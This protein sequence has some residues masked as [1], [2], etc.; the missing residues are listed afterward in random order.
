LRGKIPADCFVGAKRDYSRESKRFRHPGWAEQMTE[1]TGESRLSEQ[2][3]PIDF[4]QDDR[5]L[6]SSGRLWRMGV[7]EQIRKKL[8]NSVS[9]FHWGFM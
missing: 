5:G 9:N 8:S 7:G 2:F 3:G 6:V 4:R 1:K